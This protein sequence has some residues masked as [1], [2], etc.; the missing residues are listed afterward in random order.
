[1]NKKKMFLILKTIILMVSLLSFV[2]INI[3]CSKKYD[4][5]FINYTDQDLKVKTDFKEDYRVVGEI[6]G[7]STFL[8]RAGFSNILSSDTNYYIL[9]IQGETLE[10]IKLNIKTFKSSYYV[11][12]D[13]LIVIEIH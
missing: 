12:D 9:N 7:E 3:S 1:M 6:D 4:I 5:L 10:V 11:Y 2:F 13:S 8:Y